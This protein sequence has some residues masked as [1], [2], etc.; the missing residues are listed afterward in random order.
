METPRRTW[1]LALLLPALL[2]SC[3]FDSF[4]SRTEQVSATSAK[5]LGVFGFPGELANAAALRPIFDAVCGVARTL[6]GI[7]DR[8]A[9]LFSA[10]TESAEATPEPQDP[11]PAGGKPGPPR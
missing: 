2:W 5:V 9:G 3:S 1:L 4:C 8:V 6:E 10:E 7:Y 11:P